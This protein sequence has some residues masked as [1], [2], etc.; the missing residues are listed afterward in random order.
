MIQ[1][2]RDFGFQGKF[3]IYKVKTAIKFNGSG[4]QVMVFLVYFLTIKGI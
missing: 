2:Y 1:G 3:C 4:K